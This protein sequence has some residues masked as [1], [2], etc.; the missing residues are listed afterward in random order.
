MQKRV[1]NE[2]LRSLLTCGIENVSVAAATGEWHAEPKKRARVAVMDEWEDVICRCDPDVYE[3]SEILE[4]MP[5]LAMTWLQNQRR[6]K[7]QY[8]GLAEERP[9]VVA[10]RIVGPEAW[11]DL[12]EGT[13]DRVTLDGLVR[14][15]VGE[16]VAFFERVLNRPELSNYHLEPIR[17]RPAGNWAEM[18]KMCLSRGYDPEEIAD[19]ACFAPG[20]F[21]MGS[22]L[23]NWEDFVNDL[24]AP[25]P[26]EPLFT[27]VI[28]HCRRLLGERI[29]TMSLRRDTNVFE[30]D[31]Y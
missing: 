14:D 16:D 26:E 25:D 31:V 19:A 24:P 5:H 3:L 21:Y 10:L 9:V 15:S 29:E 20:M 23:D 8:P 13:E 4:A 30:G 28:D 18:V 27:E 17:R 2:T 11:S 6:L 12:L 1:P 22:D 7:K